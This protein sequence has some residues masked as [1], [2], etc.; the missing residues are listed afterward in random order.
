MI[1]ESKPPKYPILDDIEIP[2]DTLENWQR[3]ADLLAEM[4]NVPAA[5]VMRVHAHEI[6]VFVASNSPG[7]VYHP[8]E[9]TPLD[10]GLYCEM[11]MNTQRKLLVSNA[12]KDPAWEHNPDVALGM[13]SYC[14]HPLTW[15]TGE[16]FGTFCILDRKESVFNAR[17]QPI[18]DRFRDSIQLGLAN[19]YET[20]LIRSQRDAAKS[21]LLASEQRHR[22]LF[23]SSRDALMTLAPPSWLFTSAN[24]ATLALFGAASAAEFTALGPWS[25]SPE[26][27]PDGRRSDEKA[28]EM[29]ATAMREGK[30]FF[31]WEHCRLD[32][33]PFITDVLLTRMEVGDDVFLQAT[34]R[35]ITERK[36]AEES[37][38]RNAAR[39]QKS[40]EQ[41]IQTIADTVEARDPYTAGHERR[42]GM[43]AV[44][45]AREL[46][47]AE[48][49]IHGIRLAAS[50][51]DLGKIRIPAEILSKP[52]KL[53]DIEFML[54]KTHPQAG[55][56]ILKDVDFPWPIAM[57][58]YQHHE[59]LD[60]SGY[61][62]GLKGEAILLESRIM[63]VADVIE[64]MASHRP[65]R[66]SMGIEIALAEIER[67]CGIVYDPAVVDACVKLFHE[68]RFTFQG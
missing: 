5:L 6:E 60:G 14:G 24:K 29:I 30:N 11:V 62:Q 59:R 1:N 37:L 48:E 67:G 3:T 10:M 39:L 23:E 25:V 28:Q 15:P 19:I 35:D 56:D 22:L 43:L 33:K 41:S 45:I 46:G 42:V 50:I 13:I 36:K 18:M 21:E 27:Q 53:T 2:K 16:L 55:Y 57:I 66:P 31:E 64:A 12:L 65:Y 49:R 52:G 32:G 40:L 20:S 63:A 34:V 9:K 54:L 58:V 51:H 47:L 8:G 68:G 17:T 26:R 4:V 61:P 7:N 38:V 44:A